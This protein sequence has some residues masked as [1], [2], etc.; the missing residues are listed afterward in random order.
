MSNRRPTMGNGRRDYTMDELFHVRHGFAFDGKYFAEEGRYV[1]LTPGNFYDEGGFKFKEKEKYFTGEVDEKYILHRGDLLVAMTEQA[2]GLLGSSAI[3][4]ES[5][6]LLHNQRLGLITDLRTD[7]ID[8]K[9]LYYLF[10]SRAV[11]SQ[12]RASSS[13]V[14]V[15]HTSPARI[16]E[17]KVRI[18]SVPTQAKIAA[19]LSAYDDLIENNT[20]R[21]RI[22]EE[23]AGALYREWFVH[24]RFPGHEKAKKVDSALGR[25]PAGWEVKRLAEVAT[26]SREGI[27]P[28]DF[29]DEVF[30]HFS[31]PAFDKGCMPALEEGRTIKSNK[32]MVTEAAVLLSKLNPRIPRVWMPMLDGA[33]RAVASTE[34]L[35]LTP[36]PHF[37]REMLF[38]LCKSAEFLA[39]FT[40]RSVG[41]S[42]SHQRVKPDD[43]LK[44]EVVSPPEIVVNRFTGSAALMLGLA[45]TLRV[46]NANLR[47]TRDLLLPKL[48]SGEVDVTDLDIDVRPL[49]AV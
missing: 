33:S 12:I 48:I 41:T 8:K 13:G 31:I 11:R 29:E 35:L 16:G 36:Q 19:I 25:I 5:G 6:R 26:L 47:R 43:V 32:F 1:L 37:T 28:G 10:N 44:M 34:F 15:R 27:N 18:P 7:R 24:F 3:I 45:H 38:S 40:G 23:M 49:A 46:K 39:E 14:K 21:I 30:A 4:P 9:F 42:T 17:V 22:L 20:R 2:E